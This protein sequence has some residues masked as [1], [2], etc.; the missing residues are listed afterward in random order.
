MLI[1]VNLARSTVYEIK[2]AM[3][4]CYNVVSINII[5]M[6]KT[7]LVKIDHQF[8]R[9]WYETKYMWKWTLPF[10]SY[11]EMT[12]RSWNSKRSTP[13]PHDG[14]YWCTTV[15]CYNIGP[16]LAIKHLEINDLSSMHIIVCFFVVS[17][18]LLQNIVALHTFL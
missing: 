6:F 5:N 17:T 9:H 14:D 3:V 4:Y 8:Q 13:L 10:Y 11:M 7:N 16:L 12:Y 1:N 18:H 2:K 15:Y